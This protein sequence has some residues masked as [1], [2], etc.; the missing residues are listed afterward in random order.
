M[1]EA[2]SLRNK[3][4]LSSDNK[5]IGVIQNIIFE[6]DPNNPLAYILV[7]LKQPNWLK[8]YIT[9]NWGSISIK[10]IIA[11]IPEQ[12]TQISIDLK[13][14]GEA[15]TLKIWGAYLKNKAAKNNASL[16][17]YMFPSNFL[18]EASCK[19]KEIKLKTPEKDLNDFLSIDIPPMA[20]S[21][22]DMYAFYENSLE[23]QLDC[24]IPVTLNKIPLHL[25]TLKDNLHNKGLISDVQID[26]I[27][28][29]V[30]YFIV[31][32]MGLNAGKRLVSLNEIDFTTQKIVDTKNFAS[33]PLT[34][35]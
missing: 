22:E 1:I 7:F 30:A 32:V 23:R 34:N 9:D 24:V 12:A 5:T 26:S 13:E 4:V 2:G 29:Q 33:C 17:C 28:G 8:K 25:K 11:L 19:E 27:N 6:T 3:T 31:N 16:K 10:T 14:K 18:D 20:Q 15:E 35:D 21:T